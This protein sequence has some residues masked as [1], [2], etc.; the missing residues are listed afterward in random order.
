MSD[1]NEA[2]EVAQDIRLGRA[3]RFDEREVL[4]TLKREGA[5]KEPV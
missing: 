3:L 4:D 2:G 1:D 5:T